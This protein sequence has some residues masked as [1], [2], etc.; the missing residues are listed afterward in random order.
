MYPAH[1]FLSRTLN[2]PTPWRLLS[3]P[4]HLFGTLS[5][6]T[7]NPLAVYPAISRACASIPLPCYL[8]CSLLTYIY[9]ALQGAAAKPAAASPAAAKPEPKSRVGSIYPAHISRTIIPILHT[10][11]SRAMT[12]IFGSIRSLTSIRHSIKLRIPLAVYP[13]YIPISRAYASI[14]LPRYLA[15]SLLTYTYLA[16]Q[17]GTSSRNTKDD[18]DDDDDD[19]EDDDDDQEGDEG[20]AGG[21][22]DDNEDDDDEEDGNADGDEGGADG[23]EGGEEGGDEKGDNENHFGDTENDDDQAAPIDP[24]LQSVHT[25]PLASHP[26]IL[27]PCVYPAHSRLYIY[28]ASSPLSRTLVSI[29]CIRM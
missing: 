22:D 10:H 2:N 9:L 14:P 18:D 12:S 1:S 7:S 27:H 8:A 26:L 11:R 16:L 17:R 29:L 25:S 15:H 4:S 13:A 19:D 3:A 23:D 5:H 21:D 28:P 6:F 20:D 24:R